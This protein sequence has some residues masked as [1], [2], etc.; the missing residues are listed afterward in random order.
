MLSSVKIKFI[1]ESRQ[2]LKAISENST[3]RLFMF[4]ANV[5]IQD[6]VNDDFLD[7]C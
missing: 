2:G 4:L 5:L 1:S 6:Y 3:M 7:E